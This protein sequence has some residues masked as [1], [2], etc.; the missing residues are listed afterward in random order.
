M[1]GIYEEPL[2]VRAHVT[3]GVCGQRWRSLP[4]VPGHPPAEDACAGA[5]AAGWRVYA[6]KRSQ[7]AYCPDHAPTVPM[8]LIHGRQRTEA[9]R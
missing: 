7:H 8:H 3:C 9:T 4:Y 1:S 6:G 5:W 2:T